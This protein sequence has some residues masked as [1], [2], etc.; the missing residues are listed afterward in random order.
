MP[1]SSALEVKGLYARYGAREILR[2]V[3]LCIRQGEI[4]GLLGPN[5]AGKTSLVRAICGRLKPTAGSIVIAAD[6]DRRSASRPIGLVP[7]EIALYPSLTIRENLEVFGR[8]SGLTRTA[9]RLAI[10]EACAAAHLA[11]RLHER[12]EHLSGGWKRRVNIVAAILHRPALLILDEPTVGVDIDARNALNH[13]IQTLSG[14]GMGVLLITHDL[15]QAEHLCDNVGFLLDGALDLQGPPQALLAAA[16]ADQGE[17]IADFSEILSVNEAKM[18]Q[19]MGFVTTTG[20]SSW[21]L[22][23]NRPPGHV[24]EDLE[25]AGLKPREM[26]FRRPNLD[27]LFLRLLLKQT[28]SVVE[29]AA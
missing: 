22:I 6:D 16:F 7:Q 5:G 23:G 15:H 18:L 24:A 17:F 11:E 3:D 14:H 28:T 27:S 19:E 1:R 4:F 29:G 8:L 21:H 9:T 26:H 2:G 12:V 13:I 10:E 20:G 25:R